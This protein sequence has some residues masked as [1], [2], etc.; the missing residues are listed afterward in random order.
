MFEISAN[1][2]INLNTGGGN[3]ITNPQR[4]KLQLTAKK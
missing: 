3:N 4:F 1:E 2:S